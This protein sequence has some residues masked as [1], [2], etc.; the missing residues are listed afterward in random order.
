MVPNSIMKT[1]G[2]ALKNDQNG[3]SVDDQE[4]LPEPKKWEM[5]DVGGRVG[6]AYQMDPAFDQNE[7]IHP[8]CHH[9]PSRSRRYCCFYASLS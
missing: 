3:E 2:G 6:G 1:D 9:F 8:P 7:R 5:M 4:S